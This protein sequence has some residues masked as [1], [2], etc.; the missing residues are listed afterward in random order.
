[1]VLQLLQKVPQ[2]VAQ[3]ENAF[4]LGQINMKKKSGKSEVRSLMNV[5]P[6]I[7]R[8]LE[9][10]GIITIAELARHHPDELYERLCKLTSV[11]Q[12]PCVWDVFA[13]IIHE[14][15]TGE[16]TPWWQWTQVRKIK[17]F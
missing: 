14:A 3:L 1:L 17:R 13:A 12:D 16:K 15:Q 2:L 5:G 9:L 8:D 10:L 4:K 6:A 7:Q 11:R